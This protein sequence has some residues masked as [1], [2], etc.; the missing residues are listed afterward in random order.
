MTLLAANDVLYD[1]STAVRRRLLNLRYQH[2]LAGTTVQIDR[3]PYDLPASYA[4]FD[5][6]AGN[7]AKA[8]LAVLELSGTE[9]EWQAVA[10]AN[11]EVKTTLSK[12]PR[13]RAAALLR[14]AYVL[15]MVNTHVTLE[16]P[17]LDVPTVAESEQWLT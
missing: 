15:T 1:Q 17:L 13:A 4:V 14:H 10:D 3:S 16:F 2:G 8:A 5:D 11:A 6:R 12:I 9:A 7:R